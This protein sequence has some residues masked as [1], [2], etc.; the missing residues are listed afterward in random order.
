MSTGNITQ[1][2]WQ[3]YNAPWDPELSK[4]DAEN[5]WCTRVAWYPNVCRGPYRSSKEGYSR[6]ELAADGAIHLIGILSG[7]VG[8]AALITS[9]VIHRTP[10]EITISLV[11]YCASLLTMLISSACFH[12]LVWSR[13][14]RTLQL[15]D[16]I[17]ILCLIAGTY[18][19][20]MTLACCPRILAFVWMLALISI[21]AKASRSK[22]DHVALQVPCFLLMGWCCLMVWKD[23]STVLTLQARHIMELGGILYSAGLVPWAMNKLEFHNAIWHACVLV[24]SGCFFVVLHG[25][26]S[27]PGSWKVVESGTW[28]GRQF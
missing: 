24:A 1:Q 16:H 15:A 5:Y 9:A 6:R 8:S 22:L 26:V 25:A 21:V 11:V 20:M 2:F 13:H 23:V 17:G 19:P 28:Q 10:C 14:L 4:E 27:Q 18:S 7:I 12:S 3:H